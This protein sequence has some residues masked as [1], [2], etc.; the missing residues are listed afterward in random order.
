MIE[1]KFK[2]YTIIST[3]IEPNIYLRAQVFSKVSGTKLYDVITMAVD[4]Y[5]ERNNAPIVETSK[6]T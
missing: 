2:N 6:Q 3:R 5:L 1:T 4:E